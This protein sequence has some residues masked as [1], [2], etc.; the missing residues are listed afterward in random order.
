MRK[1]QKYTDLSHQIETSGLD[2]VLAKRIKVAYWNLVLHGA[3]ANYDQALLQVKL[4]DIDE[5]SRDRA[6]WVYSH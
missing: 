2:S 1:E 3:V 5:N 6:T 4:A